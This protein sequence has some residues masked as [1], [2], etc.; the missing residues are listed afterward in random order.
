MQDERL[1]AFNGIFQIAH[2]QSLVISMGDQ[3]GT[4][5]VE[6]PDMVALEVGDVSGVISNNGIET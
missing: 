3:N 1:E 6:I 5:S 2:G 4:R